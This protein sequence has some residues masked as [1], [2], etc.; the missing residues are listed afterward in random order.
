[1]RVL[2]ILLIGLV[3]AVVSNA[4]VL[5][6]A[7]IILQRTQVVSLE[8]GKPWNLPG[9]LVDAAAGIQTYKPLVALSLIAASFIFAVFGY[10]WASR[11]DSLP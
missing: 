4:I 1:M 5:G 6:V 10:K 3:I 2:N 9:W 11:H 7:G 8:Q